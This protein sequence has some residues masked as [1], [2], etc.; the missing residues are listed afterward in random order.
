MLHQDAFIATLDEVRH[1]CTSFDIASKLV[2]REVTAESKHEFGQ[3][4]AQLGLA[5]AR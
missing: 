4:L 3:N 5:A 1:E 2:G